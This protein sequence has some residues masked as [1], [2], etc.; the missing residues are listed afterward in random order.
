VGGRHGGA[1]RGGE[2]AGGRDVIV[3]AGGDGGAGVVGAEG[4]EEEP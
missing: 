3:R 1:E 2:A 4:V